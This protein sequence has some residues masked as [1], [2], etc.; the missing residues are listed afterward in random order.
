[1]PLKW[2]NW[3]NYKM[4]FIDAPSTAFQLPI[5]HPIQQGLVCGICVYAMPLSPRIN[6]L[7]V[8]LVY[9]TTFT[10]FGSLVYNYSVSRDKKFSCSLCWV[11]L[12]YPYGEK[13]Y[14][15][16]DLNFLV[17]QLS[18]IIQSFSFNI[19][20]A[21][22]PPTTTPPSANSGISYIIASII[23]YIRF[24][25]YIKLISR[26]SLPQMSRLLS[27][28]KLKILLGKRLCKQKLRRLK[29]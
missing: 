17:R 1:M 5:L 9:M 19:P 21:L 10:F 3:V 28:G 13:G 29:Q 2:L 6:Q 14:K 12:G 4:E 16:N 23:S 20:T 7:L 27:R 24:P 25:L 18:T 26:P 22:A 8:L 11:F 15:V